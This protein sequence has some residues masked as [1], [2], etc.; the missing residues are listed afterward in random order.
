MEPSPAPPSG[1]APECYFY[2]TQK[3]LR[4]LCITI[5]FTSIFTLHIGSMLIFFVVILETKKLLIIHS[6][7]FTHLSDAPKLLCK[8]DVLII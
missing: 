6:F 7:V 4:F 2:V 1:D 5:Y 8:K 3:K